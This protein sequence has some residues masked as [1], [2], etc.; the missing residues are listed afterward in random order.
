V[1]APLP[2]ASSPEPGIARDCCAIRFTRAQA[3]PRSPAITFLRQSAVL[4]GPTFKIRPE[5]S[6]PA[7]CPLAQPRAEHSRAAPYSA[8]SCPC[9]IVDTL[10]C[11]RSASASRRHGFALESGA[12]STSSSPTP[13]PTPHCTGIPVCT[14]RRAASPPPVYVAVDPA[15]PSSSTFSLGKHLGDPRLLL[16]THPSPSEVRTPL[17]GASTLLGTATAAAPM[18]P[19]HPGPS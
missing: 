3:P 6:T 1:R 16:H 19:S 14:L 4:L 12:S 9:A 11:R 17:T 15:R 10:F 13:T 5:A 18:P 8:A 2:E 7:P